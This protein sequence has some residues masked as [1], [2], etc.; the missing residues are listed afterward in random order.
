MGI[1]MTRREQAHRVQSGELLERSSEGIN[2]PSCNLAGFQC[3]REGL[4]KGVILRLHFDIFPPTTTEMQINS[5]LEII[6]PTG[7]GV[8]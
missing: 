8:K 4:P 3:V 1:G 2:V 6:T 7:E 5:W